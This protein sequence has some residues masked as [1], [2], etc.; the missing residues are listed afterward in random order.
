ME[1]L[2]ECSEMIGQELFL[3]N[4]DFRRELVLGAQRKKEEG[5]VGGER[6]EGDG[7]GEREGGG[8]EVSK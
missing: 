8:E 3:F 4:Q 6:G 1:R 2:Q 5:A 7:G